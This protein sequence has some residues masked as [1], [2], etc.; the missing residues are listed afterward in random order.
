MKHEPSQKINLLVITQLF[1]SPH[2]TSFSGSFVVQQLKALLPYARITVIVPYGKI[3]HNTILNN[4]AHQNANE[5]KVH[6]IAYSNFFVLVARTIKRFFAPS[7][8]IYRAFNHYES[9]LQCKLKTKIGKKIMLLSGK[10]HSK[11][12]FQLAHG[13]ELYIGDEA[14]R[15]G[16]L[17]KIPSLI[18]IHASYDFHL[19]MWGEDA[20]RLVVANLNTADA[21]ITVSDITKQSYSR[22]M[23]RPIRIISNGFTTLSIQ[24]LPNNIKHFIGNNKVVLYV[25]FL[26]PSKRV[27]LLLE[28]FSKVNRGLNNIARLLIVGLGSERKKLE[29]Y[30][31]DHSI[32]HQVM[33]VGEVKPEK[34]SA[35]YKASDVL[36]Q[37][38]INESFSMSC[39]E[40][41]AY[42]TPFICTNKAGIS[43]Y[44]I[45]G[46]EGFVIEPNSIAP[47]VTKLK[48]LLSD[49]KLR[50][51]MGN[52]AIQTA[53]KFSW[54]IKINE[55]IKLYKKLIK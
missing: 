36:V 45:N 42:G 9:L 20:M 8:L 19:K 48:L 2:G 33:F 5:I 34:M 22:Y 46:L 6:Y 51:R 31:F 27:E 14:A 30:C 18:T 21:L 32:S 13:Q 49:D 29:K 37:P 47:L 39:L 50:Y 41:M 15:V 35:Y 11:H 55:T 28:A 40:A 3:L 52:N 26:I 24:S 4:H 43:E 17:L 25:G 12:R 38:S 7:S 53:N 23:H 54:D 10:L 44:I 1:P 16:T